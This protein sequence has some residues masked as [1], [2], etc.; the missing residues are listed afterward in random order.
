MGHGSTHWTGS[1][2]L[3]Y[4][5]RACRFRNKN[6]PD[7]PNGG[8]TGQ[9]R[10]AVGETP[11]SVRSAAYEKRRM[12]RQV[13]NRLGLTAG[14][15]GGSNA[16]EGKDGGE[17]KEESAAD[18]MQKLWTVENLLTVETEW[19]RFALFAVS[20][21]VYFVRSRML[22][23]LHFSLNSAYLHESVL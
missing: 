23:A 6:A 20:E 11:S 12:Q 21:T 19:F 13:A 1:E 10:K 5:E 4:G 17:Q 9:E 8:E 15:L 3:Q 2:L 18:V 22:C 7:K 14:G 16:E